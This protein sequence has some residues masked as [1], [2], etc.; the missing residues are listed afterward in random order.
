M[1]DT[2]RSSK[3]RTEPGK[4]DV[5][6]HAATGASWSSLRK[7]ARAMR[8]DKVDQARQVIIDM[9]EKSGKRRA[10]VYLNAHARRRQP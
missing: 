5:K 9:A 3:Y 10:K 2:Y 4:G 7:L 1:F 6:L 8:R